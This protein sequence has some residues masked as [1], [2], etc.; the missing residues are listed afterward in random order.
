MLF[1]GK[2]AGLRGAFAMQ[3][4]LTLNQR[5]QLIDVQQAFAAYRTALQTFDKSNKGSMAWKR[6][7]GHEYLYR[8]EGKRQS[9]LGRRTVETERIKADYTRSR[10]A[11]RANLT[12]MRKSIEAMA[13]VNRALGLARVPRLA[14]N[15]IRALDK[16]RLLG[17]GLFVVDTHALFAYEAASGV[18]FKQDVLT[19]QDLDLLADTRSQLVVAL[20]AGERGDGVLACLQKVDP[21][22]VL[23]K[24]GFRAI[25][26]SNYLVDVIRPTTRN[27][28]SSTD[29][30][31]GGFVPVGID[32]LSWLVNAPR[33]EAIAIAEDGIPVWMPCIDPRAFALHKL[34]LS[35][36]PDRRALA[37]PRDRAQAEAVAGVARLLG[38]EFSKRA[39][40]A[41]PKALFDDAAGIMKVAKKSVT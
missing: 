18:I 32:G 7:G 29:I 10:T 2:V 36:R 20:A 17:D 38:L 6:S 4:E 33:F 21:S 8:I 25:N 3:S 22:F 23:Q 1:Y 26:D 28:A 41:L 13:A 12:K 40:S 16:Q 30:N 11:S 31:L 37:K 9:S 5:R 34:W 15:L 27:E 14:A 19:T 24:S 39:L 35:K